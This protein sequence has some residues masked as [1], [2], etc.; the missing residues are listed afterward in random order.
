MRWIPTAVSYPLDGVSHFRMFRDNAR[1]VALQ[2][3]LA[4]GMLRRLPR[5]LRRS[6]S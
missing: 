3:R 6:A 2:I 1:M 4:G 5:L